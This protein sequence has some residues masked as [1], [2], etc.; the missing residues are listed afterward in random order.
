MIRKLTLYIG[1]YIS[2]IFFVPLGSFITPTGTAYAAHCC[3]TCPCSSCC[4]FI[5][6]TSSGCT[7]VS[8]NE[9]GT[10]GDPETTLGHITQEFNNHRDWMVN[11]FLRDGNPND[12]PG[13]IAS[14]Q[15]MTSEI[16]TLGMQNVTAVGM[17][18]DAKHQLE[19]QR[20]F[21]T[22][23]AKVHK[24]YHPSEGVCNVGTAIRSLAS[25]NRI[26]NV[27]QTA[28]S[29]RAINRQTLSNGTLAYKGY[30]S[31]KPSRLVDYIRHFCDQDDN[32]ENLNLLCRGSAGDRLLF[33]RDI[34]F[35]KTVAGPMTLDIDLTD[36]SVSNDEK[37]FFALMNNLFSHETFPKITQNKLVSEDN[38][39]LSI[40]GYEAILAQRALMAKRSVAINSIARI[41]ALKSKGDD[42]SEPFLYAIM[43]ELGGTSMSNVQ[44][45]NYLGDHPSYYAQMEVLTKKLYQN[46]N[47]YAE[48]MDK[49]AN[50]VRK[51]VSLQA[52]ELMQKR[53][54]YR[55]LLRSEAIIATMLETALT[56]EQ[57]FVVNNLNQALRNTGRRER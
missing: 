49:P 54:I 1:I 47:F 6:A 19:T 36:S 20:I 8:S 26:S 52:A 45:E 22:L 16:T 38:S 9:T 31:D 14:L 5:G 50:V 23:T 48:L 30:E 33:N 40:E 53:D 29:Q 28:I 35:T 46:P 21:Q 15:L 18:F 2:A 25:S 43:E 39:E 24:D 32:N 42:Q 57:D 17:F 11:T 3:P 4:G 44:I 41:G 51:D 27:S 55:S 37:S 12:L 34:D 10:V 7:C 56:E 13:V